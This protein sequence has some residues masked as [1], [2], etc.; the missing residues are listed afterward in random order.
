MAATLEAGGQ[1]PAERGIWLPQRMDEFAPELARSHKSNQTDSEGYELFM[2]ERFDWI[3]L[4]SAQ[5]WI[6]PKSQAHS[7]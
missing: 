6:N 1:W 7:H 3:H 4:G 5:R 2:P